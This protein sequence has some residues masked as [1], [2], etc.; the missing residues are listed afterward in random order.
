MTL[1]ALRKSKRIT[2]AQAAALINVSRKTYIGYEKDESKL[3]DFSTI[4]HS[5]TSAQALR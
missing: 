4:L 3:S 2:Q 1:K 5:L